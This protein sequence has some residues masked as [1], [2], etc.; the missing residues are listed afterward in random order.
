[1]GARAQV[2]I[3][4]EGVYLYTHWG[5]GELQEDV[6]IAL[7]RRQRWQDPEYLAR[8]IFSQMTKGQEAGETGFGIGT[9]MHG[10]IELLIT[11]D[12]KSQKLT[13]EDVYEKTSKTFTFSEFIESEPS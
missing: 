11:L 7:S 9:S 13:I 8:I 12:C 6:R 3:E 10:D 4:D 2:K 5:S 1:M